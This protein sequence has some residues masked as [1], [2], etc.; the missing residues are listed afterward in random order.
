MPSSAA[1][2]EQV[3]GASELRF[4]AGSRVADLPELVAGEQRKQNGVRS[5]GDAPLDRLADPPGRVGRELE[6]FAP[7]ELVDGAEQAEVSLLHEVEELKPGPLVALG[8]R[9]DEA[10]V[11][12]DER[13]ACRISVAGSAD[14]L[15]ASC[16]PR[17]VVRA[18]VLAR[19]CASF[20][21]LRQV[22]LVVSGQERTT[23]DVDE[24]QLDQVFVKVRRVPRCGHDLFPHLRPRT[25]DP[26][27]GSRTDELTP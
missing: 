20:D 18:E 5:V 11:R 13:V 7:V 4:K 21:A 23:A 2:S 10:Q 25:P 27:L 6:A 19:V 26:T 17:L 22:H 16:R 9:H 15:A 14:Q 8:D 1:I 3:G 24:V 12:L